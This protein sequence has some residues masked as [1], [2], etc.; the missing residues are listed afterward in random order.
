VARFSHAVLPGMRARRT[1]RI[2]NVASG[3]G[4][5]SIPLASAYNVS[6]TALIRL[7]ETLAHETTDAG[8]RVFA[9][10]P[11]TVRTPM[12]AFVHDPPEVGQQAPPIQQWFRELYAEGQ[13]TP[14]ERA[15][16]LVMHL[17][18]GDADVLSG[19]YLSIDDDI[20]ALVQQFATQ[21]RTDQRTLRLKP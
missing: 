3:A 18:A 6:K 8:I 15:V 14:I 12:N 17:A 11:G 20:D 21:P 19:C 4:L 2:I 1:G 9:I 10:H 5:G 7:S 13:D 16:A